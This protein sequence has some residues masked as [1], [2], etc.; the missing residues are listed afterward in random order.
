MLISL[1]LVSVPYFLFMEVLNLP[2]LCILYSVGSALFW[3]RYSLLRT[4]MLI[5]ARRIEA[6][7]KA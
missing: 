6:C 1:S 2:V 3:L 4:A 7:M 5:T